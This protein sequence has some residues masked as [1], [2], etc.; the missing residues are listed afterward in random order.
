MTTENNASNHEQGAQKP[1]GSSASSSSSGG[2]GRTISP[3]ERW[4]LIRERAY[5]LAQKRGF[6][7]GNPFEDWM[8]A[9]K[10]I[11]AKHSTDYQGVFSLTDPKE[12]TEQFKSVFAGYGLGHL[13]VDA[14][15]EKHRGSMENLAAFNRNLIDS[16]T[17]LASQQTAV[18]KDAVSEAVKSFQSVAKGRMST[19]GVAKQAELST[20]A[21]ENAMSHFMS[22]TQSVMGLSPNSPKKGDKGK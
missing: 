1:K 7:G 18:F 4:L 5:I 10:A 3:A 9:E 16:T 20:K 2:D 14:L 21:I 17:D 12:I 22:L 15:L 11:D 6:V 13:S 8:E 19:D